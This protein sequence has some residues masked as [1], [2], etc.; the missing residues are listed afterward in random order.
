MQKKLLRRLSWLSPAISLQFILKVC[1]KHC[2][3]NSLKTSV[4]GFK[5]VQSHRRQYYFAF[6]L[7]STLWSNR[8][9]T[10]DVKYAT[11]VSSFVD[12]GINVR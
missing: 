11:C 7:P 12:Y 3:K 10:F 6:K 4:W 2:K 8:A 5:I 1:A 9:K